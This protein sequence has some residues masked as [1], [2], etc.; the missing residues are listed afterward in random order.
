ML[1]LTGKLR[2]WGGGEAPLALRSDPPLPTA[3]DVAAAR[4]GAQALVGG[5]TWALSRAAKLAGLGWTLDPTGDVAVKAAA[6]MLA[7]L[8][9]DSRLAPAVAAALAV[10]PPA[11]GPAVAADEAVIAAVEAMRVQLGALIESMA[12]EA[13]SEVAASAGRGRRGGDRAARPSG[14]QRRAAR[15]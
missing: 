15:R 12:P 10:K 1:D 4:V 3:D 9:G 6:E 7:A 13:L 2:P 11:S 14:S 8:G 5:G